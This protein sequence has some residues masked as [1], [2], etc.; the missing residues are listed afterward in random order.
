MTGKI[1]ANEYPLSKIFSNDF[2]YKIP[3]Y[4]RPY[5]WTKSEAE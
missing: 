3:P 5:S 2:K 4:Q 1:S